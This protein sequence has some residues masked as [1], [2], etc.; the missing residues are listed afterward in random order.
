MMF[1]FLSILKVDFETFPDTQ[2]FFMASSPFFL[3]SKWRRMKLML[4][5][6]ESTI[7]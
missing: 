6:L 7:R 1:L 2:S 4:P 3:L 5:L